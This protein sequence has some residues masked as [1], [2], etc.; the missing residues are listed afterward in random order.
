VT[1]EHHLFKTDRSAWIAIAAPR[2]AKRIA[3][4]TDSQLNHAWDMTGEDYKRAV[5]AL[6]DATQQARV[7]DARGTK[8]RAAA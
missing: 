1:D 2:L 8:R 5:W 6:L 7:R 4:M 3:D